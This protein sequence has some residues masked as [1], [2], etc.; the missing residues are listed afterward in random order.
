MKYV[1]F[2]NTGLKVSVLCLGCMSF[3]D[4]ADYMVEEDEATKVI[5]SAW[6][7]GI[8][9]FDTA[10]VYSDGRSEEI[11]GDAVKDYGEGERSNCYQ[12]KQR[13]GHRSKLRGLSR[14][15]VM[16][17]IS[18]SLTRLKIDYVDLYQT[19]RWDYDTPI[20]E[21]LSGADR[22]GPETVESGTSV[23]PACGRGS[24]RG[25]SILK[26]DAGI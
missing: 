12:S 16:W 5:A 1:R 26:R 15:H 25:H 22:T 11:L 7:L 23:R 20:E 9:F 8:N 21:T 18:E 4:G 19:H 10:N 13:H 3:G 14:K 24:F 17:Q 6:D 2:G